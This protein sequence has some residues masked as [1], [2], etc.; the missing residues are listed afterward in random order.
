M[1]KLAMAVHVTE[2]HRHTTQDGGVW[3]AAHFATF[4]LP[5]TERTKGCVKYNS[6]KGSED[7]AENGGFDGD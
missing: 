5:G 7:R 6:F 2:A 4:L 3:E 1:Y